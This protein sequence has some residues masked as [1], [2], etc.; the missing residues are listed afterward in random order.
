MGLHVILDFHAIIEFKDISV[1]INSTSI[2]FTSLMIYKFQ[3]AKLLLSVS[4]T[5]YCLVVVE[6]IICKMDSSMYSSF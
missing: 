2:N 6:K 5:T 3:C 4:L 1:G